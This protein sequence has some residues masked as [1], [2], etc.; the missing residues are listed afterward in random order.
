MFT[1]TRYSNYGGRKTQSGGNPQEIGRD[2]FVPKG[3]G[4]PA[5]L[6]PG[7]PATYDA[8]KTRYPSTDKHVFMSTDAVKVK[9]VAPWASGGGPAMKT[10]TAPKGRPEPF[11]TVKSSGR[12]QFIPKDMPK[13]L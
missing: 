8:V 2:K 10:F 1:T 6:H 3:H 5:G 4:A 12:D 7:Q 11:A 13:V 9:K